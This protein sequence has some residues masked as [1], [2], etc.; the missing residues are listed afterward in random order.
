NRVWQRD[1]RDRHQ[2]QPDAL[3]AVD[4]LPSQAMLETPMNAVTTRFVR[5][6]TNKYRCPIFCVTWTPEGRRLVTGASSGE[7]TL[8]NGLTFNFETILQAHE[9]A[10]RAMRWSHSD[11]WMVTADHAGYIKYWQSNMNNVKMFQAHKEPVRGISFCPSDTKFAS[12]S[13]DGTVRLWDFMRCH[14]EKILR[15]HGADVRCVDWHPHKALIA[16]GSKDN[17]QPVKLWDPRTGHSLAT[18][19]A[20]KHTVM[21]LK[22]NQNGNW[23]LTASRDHLL[24]LFDIRNLKEEVQTFKGH[25]REA[26]AI[27]W[28]PIHEGLFSSGSAD[29]ALMFWMVG[30]DHEVGAMEEAHEGMVWSVAWHPLGHILASGS[31]D[32][33]TKFWTRNRPGDEMRDKY[34][35]NTLPMGMM[36][37]EL[38]EYN[39]ETAVPNLPG[40]GMEQ[41]VEEGAQMKEEQEENE[42]PAIPGLNWEEDAALLKVEERAAQKKIPYARP[43]PKVFE[44]AWTGEIDVDQLKKEQQQQQQKAQFMPPQSSLLLAQQFIGAAIAGTL[45]QQLAANEAARM[46]LPRSQLMMGPGAPRMIIAPGQPVVGPHPGQMVLFPGVQAI[47]AQSLGQLLLQQHQN[48]SNSQQQQGIAG[49]MAANM[50]NQANSGGPQNRPGNNM[51]PPQQGGQASQ[52]T[53]NQNQPPGMGQMQGQNQ[54]PGQQVR[55]MTPQGMNRPQGQNLDSPGQMRPPGQMGDPKGPM[56]PSGGQKGNAPDMRPPGQIPDSQGHSRHPGGQMGD[57]KGPLRPQGQMGDNQGQMRHP[58]QMGDNQGQMRHPGQ[59]GDSQGQMKLQGLQGGGPQLQGQQPGNLKPHIP[60]QQFQA[61]N[62]AQGPFGSGPL[63]QRHGN[64]GG[65]P[66]LDRDERFQG[67]REGQVG[68]PADVGLD[69][70]Y[71][72]QVFNGP[73]GPSN[74]EDQDFRQQGPG[75]GQNMGGRL[76]N[77][78]DL[79]NQSDQDFQVSGRDHRGQGDDFQGSHMGGGNYDEEENYGEYGDVD[80][81]F[82]EHDVDRRINSRGGGDLNSREE[83]WTDY[84]RQKYADEN[85]DSGGYSNEYGEMYEGQEDRGDRG[86]KRVWDEGP[87][88]RGGRSNWGQ[89]EGRGHSRGGF[90]GNRGRSGG[91]KGSGWSRGAGDERGVGGERGARGDRGARG[92]GG[93]RGA[94]SGGGDRGA[95]GGGGDRGARGGGDRG[96]RGG[97]DRGARGDRGGRGGDRGSR[98]G[99]GDRGAWS[100]GDNRGGY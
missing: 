88:L 90:R 58:G 64:R 100:R 1:R 86:M 75:P 15:G 21:D 89:G 55:P 92:V 82:A 77:L 27:G 70:D 5:T 79:R 30:C 83:G 8:W 84:G 74:Y 96:A 38:L 81:R 6:S 68:G 33:A 85:W 99:R 31:N 67:Q 73:A 9:T 39:M 22:W 16:S 19:H 65:P 42:L 59:M 93:E 44:Q 97:G 23:M 43:V 53:N 12:C 49:N 24:K 56:R 87:G 32:H 48:N 80:E 28:H 71:R 45:R 52:G 98:S 95:R 17:Q 66:D 20:H 63:L 76:P 35:L 72:S 7:F 11:T 54:G 3:Y 69:H 46:M 40:I 94:R 26:T 13:D 37:Q 51:G 62:G 41:G 25:K 47:T 10:V 2:I 4:L 91:F 61:P 60:G 34:N 29:G 14:E 57:Y 18:L 78:G 36:E 50:N